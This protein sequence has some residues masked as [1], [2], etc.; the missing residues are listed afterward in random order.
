MNGVEAP[1]KNL[2]ERKLQEI[3]GAPAL[4]EH[5]KDKNNERPISLG[6][7]VVS[8]KIIKKYRDSIKTRVDELSTSIH[9]ATAPNLEN[10]KN[11]KEELLKEL[12]LINS[13]GF[14]EVSEIK[15]LLREGMDDIIAKYWNNEGSANHAYERAILEDARNEILISAELAPLV[16]KILDNYLQTAR[17]KKEKLSEQIMGSAPL[18]NASTARENIQELA[19]YIRMISSV[20]LPAF[21]KIAGELVSANT[22][23]G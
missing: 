22:P 20:C 19:W 15:K 14:L 5:K 4:A 6:T 17:H 23:R 7:A 12:R 1:G 21:K 18:I 10:A 11:E 8:A 13:S 9:N 3:A 2:N 16:V